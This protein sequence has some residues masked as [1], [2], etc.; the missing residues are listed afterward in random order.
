[1]WR[2]DYENGIVLWCPK[3]VSATINLGSTFYRLRGTQQ[4]A[5]NSAAA[6][7]S[8]TF[9]VKNIPYWTGQTRTSVTIAGREGLILSRT[10]T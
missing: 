2:R 4:P 10:P 1:V 5:V 7:T 8:V 9:G 6:T 3:G